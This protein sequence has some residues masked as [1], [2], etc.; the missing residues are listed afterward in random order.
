M[1]DDFDMVN[2]GEG[3]WTVNTLPLVA[4][5]HAYSLVMDGVAVAGRDLRAG[6]VATRPT[7]PAAIRERINPNRRRTLP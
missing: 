4:G 2:D 3:A 5:F 1:G 6:Q 7:I